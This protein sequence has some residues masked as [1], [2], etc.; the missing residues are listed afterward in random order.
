[1]GQFREMDLLSYT[2]TEKLNSQGFINLLDDGFIQF[3]HDNFEYHNLIFDGAPDQ[4]FN[5]FMFIE[6]RLIVHFFKLKK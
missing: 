5:I 2:Y 3:I 4:I 6:R 1:M